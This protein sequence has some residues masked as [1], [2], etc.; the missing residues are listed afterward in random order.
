MPLV[1]SIYNNNIRMLKITWKSG[2]KCS[3]LLGLNNEYTNNKPHDLLPGIF[4]YISSGV[5]Y[6]TYFYSTDF[7]C[8][9]NYQ[10]SALTR[11]TKSLR[12]QK[13]LHIY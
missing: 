2:F 8:P 3:P 12:P 4:H 1:L 11:E 7:G 5:S 9:L 10:L 13:L 6:N